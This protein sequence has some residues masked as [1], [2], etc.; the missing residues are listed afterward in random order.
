MFCNSVH[1]TRLTIAD[2][3]EQEFLVRGRNVISEAEDE[4]LIFYD[5]VTKVH[6]LPE[7]RSFTVQIITPDLEIEMDFPDAERV[8]EALE[9]FESKKVAEVD[10]E[11]P[12]SVRLAPLEA[13]PV[14]H[15]SERGGAVSAPVAESLA[16]S[17]GDVLI[18]PDPDNTLEQIPARPDERPR[19]NLPNTQPREKGSG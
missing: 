16:A 19:E 18:A 7:D 1:M 6:V 9:L 11:A 2:A 13:E 3:G 12:G 17:P 4:G 15:G 14:T 5:D 8:R 10:A